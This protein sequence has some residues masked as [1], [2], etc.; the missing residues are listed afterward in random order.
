MGHTPVAPGDCSPPVLQLIL[1]LLVP[2]RPPHAAAAH[3]LPLRPAP[4]P[5]P[6]AAS[7]SAPLLAT[8]GGSL[9]LGIAYSTDVPFLRWKR[10]PVLAAACILAVR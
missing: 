9:L 5:R 10:F 2:G 8:L 4:R 6:P 7:G 1:G 3:P